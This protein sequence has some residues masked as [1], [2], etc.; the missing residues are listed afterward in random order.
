MRSAGRLWRRISLAA[1]VVLVALY[2]WQAQE[3]Y[4]HGGS[5]LGLILGFLALALILLLLFYGVRKRRYRNTAGR[6]ETWLQSHIYLGALCLVV[7]LLHTGFRFQD[8]LALAAFAVLAAVVLSGLLGAILYASV[9]RL[10]TEVESDLSVAE[11]DDRL[12]QLAGSMARLAAGKSALFGRIQRS[13]LAESRPGR[14]AGWRLALGPSRAP[15]ASKGGDPPAWEALL[16]RVD[17]AEREDL[18]RLL[19]LSRQH[20]E[21]HQKLRYQQRYRN[22]LEAWLWLHLPLSLVLLVLVLAHSVTALY[23]RGV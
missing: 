1:L 17:P 13:V 8:R 7:A 2:V 10:L 19:V 20:K 16:D 21:L 6:M 4:A 3:A 22:L 15:A 18:R 11:M 14:F 23:Y 12:H 9:P 5:A